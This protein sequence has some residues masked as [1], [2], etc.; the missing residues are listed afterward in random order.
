MNVLKEFITVPVKITEN[1]TTPQE[2]LNVFV[3]MVMKRIA[4]EHV[5]VS[6]NVQLSQQCTLNNILSTS[7]I[8]EC[9][10]ET[11]LCEQNCTNTLGSYDCSC[12]DGFDEDGFNCIGMLMLI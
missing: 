11:D 1:V 6:N 12:R 9:L 8:D 10:A 5:W 7:D 2:G 3:A 4:M